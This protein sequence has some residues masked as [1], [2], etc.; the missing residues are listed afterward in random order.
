MSTPGPR[1][2]LRKT[3]FIA[4][5]FVFTLL[6]AC[7]APYARRYP[8]VGEIV[9]ID[10]RGH[11][12]ILRHEDIPNFMKGMTMPFVVKDD[13]ILDR[14][15]IGQR[16]KATL[17]VTDTTSWLEDVQVTAPAPAPADPSPPKSELQIPSE[18]QP[19][20]DFVF[21]NQ[22]G[23]RIHLSQYRGKAVLLTFI[24]TRCPLPDYCPRMTHN[25]AEIEKALKQDPAAYDRTHLLSI[26]FDPEFDTPRVLRQHALAVAS[27]PANE[28]FRHWEFA[29]PNAKD[30]DA[31]AHFFALSQWKEDGQIVHSLSTAIIDP[32]GKI[33]RWYH[34]NSWTT[35]EVL[36]ETRAAA[37]KL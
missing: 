34:G 13:K 33:Y 10:R 6:A 16:I 29:A 25:F 31:L 28:L 7:R 2:V 32:D 23:R 8:L 9:G 18:G 5:F 19:V 37:G 3:Q 14:V 11:Q 35:E 4:L 12:L 27:I 21:T 24:Y 17:A 30:L 26:S 22:D 36:R 15:Q 20:P 1:I